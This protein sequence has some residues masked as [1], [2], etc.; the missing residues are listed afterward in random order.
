MSK[1]Y[2]YFVDLVFREI[3]KEVVTTTTQK[4]KV[5]LPYRSSYHLSDSEWNQH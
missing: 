3:Q 4:G 5:F 1:D 2:F